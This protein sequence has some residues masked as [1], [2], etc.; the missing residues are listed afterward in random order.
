[1]TTTPKKFLFFNCGFWRY[2]KTIVTVLV[3]FLKNSQKLKSCVFSASD[4]TLHQMKKVPHKSEIVTYLPLL[5][6]QK[7]SF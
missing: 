1:M 2:R 5:L 6:F 4:L 3:Q 7:V